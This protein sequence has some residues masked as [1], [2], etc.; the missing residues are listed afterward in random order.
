MYIKN[1]TLHASHES[2]TQGAA[3]NSLDAVPGTHG[4]GT[5]SRIA[6]WYYSE[7]NKVHTYIHIKKFI[8]KSILK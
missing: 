2:L 6:G 5:S 4:Q 1:F 7:K 8:N 3:Y